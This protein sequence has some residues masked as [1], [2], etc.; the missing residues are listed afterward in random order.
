MGRSQFLL[1]LVG[2]GDDDAI[3]LEVAHGLGAGSLGEQTVQQ[4]LADF[5]V[6]VF[7]DGSSCKQTL[8]I[9]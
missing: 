4:F 7:P 6:S 5:Q 2:A 1:H 8:H 3:E 9:L